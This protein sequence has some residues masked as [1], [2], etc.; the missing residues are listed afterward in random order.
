[1][2]LY[3]P[4]SLDIRVMILNEGRLSIS[5]DRHVCTRA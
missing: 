1:M 3:Q 4:D 5:V 2:T